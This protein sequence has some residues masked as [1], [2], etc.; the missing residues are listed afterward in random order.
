M[1]NVA[2]NPPLYSLE[3]ASDSPADGA[4]GPQILIVPISDSVQF[5]KGYLGADGETAA[6]EGELQMKGVRAGRW[7]KVTMSLSS[8]ETAFDNTIEL[9][10]TEITLLDSSIVPDSQ[11][12][13]SIA[14]AVPLTPDAPQCIHTPYS[15]LSYTITATLHSATSS[16]PNISKSLTVHTRRYTP[17]TLNL[18]LAPRTV[19]KNFPTPIEVQVPRTRYKAG[20]PIPLYVTVPPP[21]RELVV[22]LGVRLRNVKAELVRIVKVLRPG[23]EDLPDAT[24]E[25]DVEHADGEP[26]AST[27][28]STDKSAQAAATTSDRA[29]TSSSYRGFTHKTVIAKSGAPC[30]FH[31]TRPIR[32]RLVLHP[33]YTGSPSQPSAEPDTDSACA[34]I[35]QSTLLHSVSFRL[36]TQVAFVDMSTHIERVSTMT[37]PITLLPPSAPLPEVDDDISEQYHKKHD[38][39]PARTVRLDDAEERV[40]GYEVGVAGPSGLSAGAPPPFEEREAPPPFFPTEAEASTSSR[41][42][43]FLESESDLFV[44]PMEDPLLPPPIPEIF[45]G[46]GT[47]FG[48]SISEQFDGHAEDMRRTHSPPPTMEEARRDPDVTGL[49]VLE[50]P[51]RAIEALE[52]A[53][54][55]HEE[56]SRGEHPPPPPPPLDDPS[57]PPPSIDSDFRSPVIQTQDGPHSRSTVPTYE[58]PPPGLGN[59]AAP[60][61]NSTDAPTTDEHAPP[62]YLVPESVAGN[63]HTSGPPPYIDVMHE[64]H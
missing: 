22:D 18:D 57:D 27:S 5:Q 47:L 37:V 20:E 11:W 26:V 44:A 14:F 29:T 55:Q 59:T 32:L 8:K 1:S 56:A 36:R 46:E 10:T 38:Q 12:P 42:P 9:G 64:Q 50:E 17:H 2:D 49:T 16:Q 51:E 58:H 39:P 40:P 48:F 25:E 60:P 24:D 41:L 4:N 31:S 35:T 62:P 28:T 52:Y 13:S 15:A 7:E 19:K 63:E 54:E 43:T 33:A 53:L 61:A 30:R 34:S 23:Y 3:D 21:T 45:P 6:V